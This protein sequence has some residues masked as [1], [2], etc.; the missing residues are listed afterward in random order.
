VPNEIK[1]EVR[2]VA[3]DSGAALQKGV[4]QLREGE[5]PTKPAGLVRPKGVVVPVASANTN[6]Q[7]SGGKNSGSNQKQ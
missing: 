3:I 2:V 6:T 7:N 5:K 1:K 4:S